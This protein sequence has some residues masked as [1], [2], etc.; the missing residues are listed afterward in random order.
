MLLRHREHIER[1]EV[2]RL[3]PGFHIKLR[4]DAPNEFRLTAFRGKHPGQ[5]KQIARLHR[6]RIG[7]ERLRWRQELDAKFFQPLLG[8]GWPAA[9][10]SYHLFFRIW[11]HFSLPSMLELSGS[12][13]RPA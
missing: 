9:F 8:A 12:Y 13:Q 10:A 11:I 3:A 2:S 6:L 5:E 7:A 1:R 4:S